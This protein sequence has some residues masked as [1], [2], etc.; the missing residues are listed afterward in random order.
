MELPVRIAERKRGEIILCLYKYS[1]ILVLRQPLLC[2]FLVD[3][4]QGRRL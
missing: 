3:G 2:S 4:V 1:T